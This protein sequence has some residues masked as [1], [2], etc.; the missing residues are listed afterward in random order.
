VSYQLTPHVK[1][2]EYS[3]VFFSEVTKYIPESTPIYPRRKPLLV[4]G[5]IQKGNKKL[6]CNKYKNP[7]KGVTYITEGTGILKKLMV[8]GELIKRFLWNLEVLRSEFLQSDPRY[9]PERRKE[10]VVAC[11]LFLELQE[12]YNYQL[13]ELVLTTHREQPFGEKEIVLYHY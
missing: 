1:S 4:R 6:Y 12:S 2:R 3:R 10:G 9:Y 13:E 5:Y 7:L 11:T 8:K